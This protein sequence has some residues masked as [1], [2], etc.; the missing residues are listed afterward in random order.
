MNSIILYILGSS[1]QLLSA[2]IATPLRGRSIK[3]T[4]YPL[5]FREFLKFKNATINTKNPTTKDKAILARYLDEYLQFGGFPEVVLE[6][7]PTEK[8]KILKEYL[9]LTIYKDIA[10]RYQLRNMRIMKRT[11]DQLTAH[12]TKEVRQIGRASCRERV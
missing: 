12:A 1:S 3:Q 2:E 6:E 7:H 8:L 9:E 5:S 11:I 4:L 10:E